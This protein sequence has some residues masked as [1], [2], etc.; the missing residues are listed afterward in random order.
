MTRMTIHVDTLGAGQPRAYADSR[1]EAILTYEFSGDAFASRMHYHR[2]VVKRHVAAL[3]RPFVAEKGEKREWWQ[4]YL[5][6]LTEMSRNVW[7][8]KVVEPYL[9]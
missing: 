2:D 9:D 8:A 4:A 7:H 6:D 5:D 1:W 3:V